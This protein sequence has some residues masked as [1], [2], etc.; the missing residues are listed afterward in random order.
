MKRKKREVI[1]SD[2]QDKVFKKTKPSPPDWSPTRQTQ[3]TQHFDSI[4]QEHK[5]HFIQVLGS[6]SKKIPFYLDQIRGMLSSETTVVLLEAQGTV[7][8]KMVSLVERTKRQFGEHWDISQENRILERG[9]TQ[10]MQ[11]ILSIRQ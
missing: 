11:V 7:I 4:R 3:V 6:G 2:I 9:E 1:H 10:V 5:T 8:N